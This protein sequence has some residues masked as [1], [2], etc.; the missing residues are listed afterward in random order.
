MAEDSDESM[1]ICLNVGL[2]KNRN[3]FRTIKKDFTTVEIERESIDTVRKFHNFEEKIFK[4]NDTTVDIGAFFIFLKQNG[5]ESIF[6]LYFGVDG[7]LPQ[8]TA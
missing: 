7:K 6:N 5:L 4:V 8:Q 3:N 1:V 2:F